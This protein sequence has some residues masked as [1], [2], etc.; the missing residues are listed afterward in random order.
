MSSSI[1]MMNFPRYGKIKNVPNH[2]PDGNGFWN[3]NRFFVDSLLIVIMDFGMGIEFLISCNWNS[4][5]IVRTQE[6]Y[7]ENIM[8]IMVFTG[9]LEG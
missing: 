5:Q 7:N 3:G 1:G 6:G 2:Q 9:I 4:W 8:G